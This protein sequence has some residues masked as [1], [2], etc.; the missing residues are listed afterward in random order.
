[1]TGVRVNTVA[2]IVALAVVATLSPTCG[3]VAQAQIRGEIVGAGATLLPVA[4]PDL[5]RVGGTAD[6]AAA[7]T[8]VKA[9]RRDLELSGIFRVIDPA[10]YIDDPQTS[11]TTSETINFENWRSIGAMALIRGTC[12]G[13]GADMSVEVRSFDVSDHSSSGGRRL[14][15]PASQAA[16][17]GHR[18]ADAVLEY[19]TGIAGPFDSRLAFVSDRGGRFRE[20]YT[21]TFD[22]EIKRVTDHRSI[23]M[24]P[25]WHPSAQALLFTSFTNGAPVLYSLDLRTGYDS[26]LASKLGVN[27]GGAWS[28]D[29]TRILLARENNGNTDIHELDPAAGKVRA[30]T[31][32]WGID[33]DPGWSP[34]GR[35]LVFCSSRSGSPQVY[36][37]NLQGGDLRRLTFDGNYNC[38]PVWSPDGKH[39]AYAGQTNGRFQVYVMPAAGGPARQLTFSGSNEDPTWSPDSRYVAYSGKRGGRRKIYMIDIL[40]RQERQ[41]TDGTSD[42]SSPSW[43]RRLE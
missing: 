9:L 20:I 2:A 16:R 1:M 22:G 37:M 17:M 12:I 40:G 5:K 42:D 24:A 30:L 38:S 32:H 15:G 35:N 21:F 27:V 41:L 25:S 29:G 43:S 26:R 28:P 10:A 6:A 34:D 11:G 8:F 14:N 23:T 31:S 39:V 4:I 33:V 18:M 13:T 19:M 7:K 3:D 36:A